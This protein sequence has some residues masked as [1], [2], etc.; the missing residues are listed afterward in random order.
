MPRLNLT[1]AQEQQLNEWV[2]GGPTDPT[3]LT[4]WIAAHCPIPGTDPPVFDRSCYQAEGERDLYV[5]LLE[6]NGQNLRR[7][8]L[9]QKMADAFAWVDNSL[10]WADANGVAIEPHQAGMRVV[11]TFLRTL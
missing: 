4:N 8:D 7:Q 2:N 5:L 6:K 11:W 3:G 1:E 10:A 9:T